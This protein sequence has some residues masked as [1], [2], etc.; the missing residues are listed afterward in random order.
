MAAPSSSQRL[1]LICETAVQAANSS[2]CL[3]NFLVM[4]RDKAKREYFSETTQ[5]FLIVRAECA[6]PKPIAE[7]KR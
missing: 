5:V 1:S 3:R 4:L 2:G 7:R 6:S